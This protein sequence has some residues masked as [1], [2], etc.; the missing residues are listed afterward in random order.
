MNAPLFSPRNSETL[1]KYF[2]SS[3]LDGVMPEMSMASLGGLPIL[4]EA[5]HNKWQYPEIN[6]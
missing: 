4:T 2:S 3:R 1:S 6:F 5:E